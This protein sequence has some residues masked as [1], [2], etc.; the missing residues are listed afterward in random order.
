MPIPQSTVQLWPRVSVD[1][2]IVSKREMLLAVRNGTVPGLCPEEAKLVKKYK[3]CLINALNYKPVFLNH[4]HFPKGPIVI[5]HE[6]QINDYDLAKLQMIGMRF[7]MWRVHPN[8][9]S[10]L[11]AALVPVSKHM[12]A[13]WVTDRAWLIVRRWGHCKDVC[14]VVA[15][16]VYLDALAA[17]DLCR[18]QFDFC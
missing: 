7:N 14:G 8:K 2:L 16:I 1:S 17:W 12:W 4:D 9:L 15:K 18:N 5:G 13:R 11:L 6:F 10:T 3:Y